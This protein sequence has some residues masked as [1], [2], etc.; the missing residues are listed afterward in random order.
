MV[1]IDPRHGVV[2]FAS[3]STAMVAA[4]SADAHIVVSSSR[5]GGVT[6]ERPVISRGADDD[7]DQ[8]FN[9]KP[10]ILTDANPASPF[11]GRTYLTWTRFRSRH[12]ATRQ[13]PIWFAWSDDGGRRWSAPK[14]ISGFH[15]RLCSGAVDGRSGRCAG[16]QVPTPAVQPD[17]TLFVAFVNHQNEAIAE[18]GDGD[19]QY[20]V[21]RSDDGGATFSAPTHVV[22]MENGH[23]DF[24]RNVQGRPTL[25]G[26]QA[27]V[28]FPTGNLAASPVTG[29]LFLTFA[30]NRAG[31]R[32]SDAP[33]RTSTCTS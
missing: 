7:P 12:G 22:G 13:S 25:S 21:V 20:L 17:G 32:A 33:A 16:N 30:D 26:V 4:G 19:D 11:Y 5:D 24:P 27:R 3:L 23:G 1:T 14:E 28:V 6:W 29:E 2:L 9:D 31:R 18:D 10:W 8:I 15:R